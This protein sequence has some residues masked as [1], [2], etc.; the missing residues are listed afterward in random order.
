MNL[1]MP[2]GGCRIGGNA[3]IPATDKS[4]YYPRHDFIPAFDHD[5]PG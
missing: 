5:R 2:S 3:R 1:I 4:G